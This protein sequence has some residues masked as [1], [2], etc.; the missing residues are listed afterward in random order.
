[1]IDWLVLKWV[2]SGKTIKFLGLPRKDLSSANSREKDLQSHGGK[3]VS[4]VKSILRSTS[5]S[6]VCTHYIDISSR[7]VV[8]DSEDTIKA[9]ASALGRQGFINYFGLQVLS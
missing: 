8:A 7:G 9:S 6:S 4:S 2:I 1:M 3:G 5:I